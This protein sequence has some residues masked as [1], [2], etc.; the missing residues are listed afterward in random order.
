MDGLGDIQWL[1]WVALALGLGVAE[2]VSVAFVFLMFAGGAVSAALAAGLGAP[3][4]VST[5]V[6][7]LA[8][9]GLLAAVRPPLKRWALSTPTVSMNAAALV[10]RDALVIET[11]SERTGRVKL[12]G[13]IWTARVEP[14]RRPLE[15]GSAVHVV[16]IDGATA[17]VA[18]DTSAPTSLEGRSIP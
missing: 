3:P 17:V 9:A 4:A 13:E 15:V 10:G 14:G 18:P 11:V 7:A 5:I 8:S 16:R 2:L 12:A 6:F 1:L